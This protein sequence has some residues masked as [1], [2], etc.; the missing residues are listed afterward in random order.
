MMICDAITQPGTYLCLQG[1]RGNSENQTFFGPFDDKQAAIAWHDG[2]LAVQVWQDKGT[3]DFGNVAVKTYHKAF[4]VG[5]E[6]EWFNPLLPDER[7]EP[8]H[9]GHGTHTLVMETQEHLVRV[10]S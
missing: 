9:W 10:S 4:K 7:L 2:E 5:S 6:L 1:M 8:G 3:D